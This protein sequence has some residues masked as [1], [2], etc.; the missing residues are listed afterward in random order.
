[1]SRLEEGEIKKEHAK[2]TA[3]RRDVKA[4]L[5]SEDLQWETISGEVKATRETYS[6]KTK[7]HD[8]M[9]GL[10]FA[11]YNWC[12]HH[13]TIKTTPA[14]CSGLATERWTLAKLLTEAAKK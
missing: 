13:S 7:N 3:E 9:L 14:V 11:W 1:M 2:L 10:Y 6:K 4:L 5:A 8:A 12:R